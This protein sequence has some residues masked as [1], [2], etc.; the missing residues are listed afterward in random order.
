VKQSV[1]DK[2][3]KLRETKRLS[4]QNV[5][6]ELGLSSSYYARIERG[7]YDP[8]LSK[9]I[10][11]AEILEVDVAEF[12]TRDPVAGV[13][14]NKASY[15]SITKDDIEKLTQSIQIL[16]SEINKLRSELSGNKKPVLKKVKKK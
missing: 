11:L 5:A 14:E 12:F 16:F 7:K 2:I 15:G 4:Q 1:T 13:K 3:R 10:K 9:L 8:K 6:D